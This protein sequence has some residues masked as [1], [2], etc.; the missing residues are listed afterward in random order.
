MLD[1]GLTH[2]TN[3]GIRQRVKQLAPD[4]AVEIEKKDYGHIHEYG[5]LLST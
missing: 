3:E 4:H 2:Q 5:T 1:C